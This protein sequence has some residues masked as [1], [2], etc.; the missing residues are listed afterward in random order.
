MSDW[1]I[2][3]IMLAIGLGTFSL[4]LSF[5]ELLDGVAVPHAVRRA[6]RFV[7]PA[8]LSALVVPAV[9]LGSTETAPPALSARVLAGLVA[10]AIACWRRSVVW[11]LVGGMAT[12]WATDLL[13]AAV[14]LPW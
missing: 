14:G 1:T 11:T 4:R 10:L 5:I 2:W 9:L 12:L 6:L 3:A 13:T 7:P 8:V